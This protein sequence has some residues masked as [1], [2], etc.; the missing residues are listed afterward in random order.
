MMI[1]KP[2][3]AAIDRLVSEGWTVDVWPN[4]DD[5]TAYLHRRN[6]KI[7]ALTHYAQVEPD[8]TVV[9]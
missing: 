2:Q 6:R 7:R 1:P 3:S 8:G 4:D 5:E 9:K